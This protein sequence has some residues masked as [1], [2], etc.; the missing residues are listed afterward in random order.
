MGTARQRRCR[1]HDLQPS[2]PLPR[3]RG[4][5][6]RPHP[7][8]RCSRALHGIDSVHDGSLNFVTYTYVED[9]DGSYEELRARGVET[10]DA[11]GDKFYGVRE[12]LVRD[13]DGYYYAIAKTPS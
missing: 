13:P 7:R 2:F 9:V 1:A 8:P 12:F 4:T 6:A 10:L 11:P 3:L 5:R